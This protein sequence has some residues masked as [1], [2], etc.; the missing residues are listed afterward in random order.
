MPFFQIEPFQESPQFLD[1]YLSGLLDPLVSAFVDY[2]ANYASS[3]YSTNSDRSPDIIPLPR[4]ICEILYVFCKVRGYK[5]ISR[6]FNNEPRHM[7]PMLEAL[8]SWA[9]PMPTEEPSSS[10]DHVSMLW[11]E[12]YII[13]LWLS[14]LV[15]APFDFASMSSGNVGRSLGTPCLNATFP[16]GTPSIVKRLFHVSSFYLGFASKER[17]AAAILLARLAVKPDIS[18]RNLHQQILGSVCKS[19]YV[20]YSNGIGPA[21]IHDLLGQLSFLATFV[22]SAESRVLKSCIWSVK[23]LMHHLRFEKSPLR[24]EIE[25]ST[26]ARKLMIKLDKAIAIA[27]YEMDHASGAPPQE[28]RE[29]P[30]EEL[31][32]QLFVALADPDT[33]VRVAASKALSL[34]VLKLETHQVHDVLYYLDAEV[35]EKAHIWEQL[36]IG[37]IVDCASMLTVNSEGVRELPKYVKPDFSDVDAK[38]WHGVILTL[39]QLLFRS[40]VPVNYLSVAIESLLVA[41]HFEQRSSLG[42]SIGSNVRDAACFGLWSLARRYS[43]EALQGT[44]VTGQKPD[45]RLIVQRLANDLVVV[46]V[47]DP[48]GNIRRGASAALQEMVGRHPDTITHGIQII[49]TVDYHAI[50]LGSAAM[51]DVAISASEIHSTYWHAILNGLLGWRGVSSSDAVIRRRAALTLGLLTLDGGQSHLNG[52]AMISVRCKLAKTPVYN[53]EDAHGLLLALANMILSTHEILKGHRE[54]Y[55][56]QEDALSG[57][58]SHSYNENPDGTMTM[59]VRM[60]K[61]LEHVSQN[62]AP[63]GKRLALEGLCSF[64]SAITLVISDENMPEWFKSA[65]APPILGEQACIKVFKFSLRQRDSEVIRV[66]AEAAANTFAAGFCA[67]EQMVRDWV[68]DIEAAGPNSDGDLIGVAAALGS[69]FRYL[70]EPEEKSTHRG[71]YRSPYCQ[72]DPRFPPITPIRYL[73]IE[74]LIKLLERER[75]IELKCAALKSLTS[76][77]LKTKGISLHCCYCSLANIQSVHGRHFRKNIRLFG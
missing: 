30:F 24:N 21:S 48:A 19:L 37:Q 49:Q 20:R 14:H 45:S 53:L 3:Y 28:E 26:F 58:W 51:Q 65:L 5:V 34:S 69:V 11:Q 77:V 13:L 1:P 23:T 54:K 47:L 33:S 31:I 22:S 7:E 60:E 44:I 73:V 10:L 12:R 76:G 15:L 67:Q 9:N 41:L 68:G 17:E 2:V 46:A 50:A 75:S 66:A 55:L 59:N 27:T 32:S 35:K 64:I 36:E 43:T 38:K 8:E 29:N 74:T 40:A 71:R 4:A 56:L 70:K 62:G 25:R 72:Y 39:A 57:L 16:S 61:A 63:L 6:F 18:R 52:A 42:V